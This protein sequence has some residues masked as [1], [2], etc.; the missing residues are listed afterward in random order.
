[1][2]KPSLVAS[3]DTTIKIWRISTGELLQTLSG[4]SGIVTSV[5]LSPDGK[6]LAS[7]SSDKSI[8][9]WQIFGH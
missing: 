4:H 2:G 8:R 6:F 7:G 1:M 3:A 9:M 5:A